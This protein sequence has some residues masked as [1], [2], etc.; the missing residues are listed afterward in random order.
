MLYSIKASWYPAKKDVPKQDIKPGNK[1]MITYDFDGKG[2]VTV[3]FTP[4]V[5]NSSHCPKAEYF[6]VESADRV[7]A[8]SQ[9]QC[10]SSFFLY[11][12]IK[13]LT[14]QK[15]KTTQGINNTLTFTIPVQK[16]LMYLGLKAILEDGR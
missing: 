9:A 16:E 12:S 15:V 4:I 1:G 8:T 3:S 11:T 10:P 7:E 5:C 14:P 6:Y 13:S 2:S